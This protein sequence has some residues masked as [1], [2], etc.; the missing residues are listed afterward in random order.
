MYS[1]N[2]CDY[3]QWYNTIQLI[4]GWNQ[5]HEQLFTIT[6]HDIRQ[7]SLLHWFFF[8]VTFNIQMATRY[9]IYMTSQILFSKSQD[10]VHIFEKF[11]ILYAII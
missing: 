8:L 5:I 1:I 10:I 11:W 2:K 9:Y 6:C 7:N 4:L 3:M